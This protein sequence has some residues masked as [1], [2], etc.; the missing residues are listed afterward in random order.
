MD[1]LGAPREWL[2]AA[3][4]WLNAPQRRSFIV[5]GS[6][7]ILGLLV[8]LAF[9]SDLTFLHRKRANL[10]ARRSARFTRRSRTP[11]GSEIPYSA[12]S[13]EEQSAVDEDRK[14]SQAHVRELREEERADQEQYARGLQANVS[15]S[16]VIVGVLGQCG[17]LTSGRVLVGV[18]VIAALAFVAAVLQD[19]QSQERTLRE[20]T[21]MGAAWILVKV[22]SLLWIVLAA[23]L[24]LLT[25]LGGLLL[26]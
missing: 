18:L 3:D 21:S 23:P 4:A 17:V 8:S 2:D 24:V 7:W 1:A 20:A 15:T 11:W 19:P 25:S 16:C 14:R 22:I 26:P 9:A 6:T 10:Q 12:L 5:M 13:E